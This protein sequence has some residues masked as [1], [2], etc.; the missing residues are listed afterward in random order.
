MGD[1]HQ[2]MLLDFHFF[3][4]PYGSTG[5]I[6]DILD[7]GTD[8]GIDYQRLFAVKHRHFMHNQEAV[9]WIESNYGIFAS[10]VAKLHISFDIVH[11]YGK[12]KDNKRS[13]S[14]D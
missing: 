7:H 12:K 13:T 2:H 14:S 3:G 1:K 4:V 5:Y 8:V 9:A 11:S 10:L 6:H